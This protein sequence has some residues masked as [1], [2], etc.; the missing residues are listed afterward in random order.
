MMIDS[1]TP[2]GKMLEAVE[3]Y[4][5]TSLELL[6]LKTIE[7]SAAIVSAF[8]SSFILVFS[9]A[10][11]LF[12]LNIGLALWIGKLLGES[13]FG[14]LAVGGFYALLSMMLFLFGK[15]WISDRISDMVV[16]ELMKK[17]A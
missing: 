2:I 1:A 6:R 4:G 12:V 5:K 17:S 9:L 14:F 13:F 16:R 10:L 3:Q 11:S 15:S 8:V 7:L